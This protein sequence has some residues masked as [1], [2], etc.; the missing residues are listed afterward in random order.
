MPTRQN[1]LEAAA[2]NV[3]ASAILAER[4]RKIAGLASRKV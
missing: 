3:I 1:K 4:H 2:A